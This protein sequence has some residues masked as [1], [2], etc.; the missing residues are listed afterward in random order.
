MTAFCTVLAA[1][2]F[3]CEGRD[4]EAAKPAFVPSPAEA[5]QAVEASLSAWRGAPPTPSTSFDIS[6]VQFVEKSTTF[7]RRLASFQILGQTEVENARQ[8]TV[9][10]QFEGEDAPDLVKYHVIG[11]NPIWVFR[12]DDYEK[13]A[14]WEHDMTA[15][16]PGTREQANAA[17]QAAGAK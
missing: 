9:R 7:D 1:A 4:G 17:S 15:P 10:L 13:F 2:A 11:R 14:H 16:E 12:L 3:G 6:G 8:I 5:K